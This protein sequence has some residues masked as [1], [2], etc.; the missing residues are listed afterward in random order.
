MNAPTEILTP[1]GRPFDWA[2]FHGYDQPAPARYDGFT[3]EK[4]CIFL[5]ALSEGHSV[6][7]ACRIVGISKQAAYALRRS[8]RGAQF[9]LGWQ[10]AVL[11][12][13]D[14]LA[15]ELL[16]RA[17][18]GT[19]E[20][21]ALADGGTVDRRRVDNRLAMAMLNR[22]DRMAD[23]ATREAGH[24]A[25]RLVAAD[26]E[27][28]LA[29]IG[30]DAGAARAGLFVAARVEAA[31]ADDLEPIRALVRADRWLR[32]HAGLADE[33]AVDDLDPAR[34]TEWTAEQW[35]R[36]EAAGLVRLAPPP[37][38]EPAADMAV[39]KVGQPDVD[40]D[41]PD[42]EPVWWDSFAMQWRTRFPPPADFIGEEDGEYGEDLYSRELSSDEEG[43]L[44]APWLAEVAARAAVERVERDAWF[45]AL[46]AEAA[47]DDEA[48]DGAA[49]ASG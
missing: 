15:D 38:P 31:S 43:A 32:A 47:P 40:P 20:T 17:I 35:A 42:D 45:A 37:E 1:D 14:T 10:A 4:Q 12:T 49:Q 2:A 23:S 18:N 30:R 13:R 16:D 26:F 6:T 48:P 24:A 39:S 36:A 3:P 22:L 33:V 19:I 44:E 7:Q 5:Q 11:L 9:A 8:A 29:L 41:N 25:A 21:I 46:R 34:R 28:Y 27:Q